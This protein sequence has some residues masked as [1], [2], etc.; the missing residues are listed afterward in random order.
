MSSLSGIVVPDRGKGR[1]DK[2]MGIF[3]IFVSVILGI[4]EGITEWLPVSSTGHMILVNQFLN[5]SND[6][7]SEM[8]LV[9]VQLGAIMA[10]VLL[11]WKKIFPFDLRPEKGGSFVKM[12]IMQMWFKIIVACLPAAVVGILFDDVIDEMFYN[13]IVVAGAL[14][15]YGVLFILVENWNKGRRPVITKV[16]DLTYQTA[17]IIGVFQLLAAVIPGTSRSGATIVGALIIGVSRGVAAEFTFYLAIP[18]MF[19]ASLLKI[20]KS[21]MDGLNYGPMEITTL[22]VGMI[23]AFIVSLFV[24]KF[25]M[26]YIRRHDFKV[27]GYYRIVLGIIVLLYF[28]ISGATPV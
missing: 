22:L 20:I 25:L 9:V 6:K 17:L 23:V 28:G 18:V 8:F 3:D 2:I 14:I 24:I 15:I 26:G 16:H 11:F 1:E 10:V 5:F 27:F 19:G 7:F 12:D 21:V 4:V 13:Q